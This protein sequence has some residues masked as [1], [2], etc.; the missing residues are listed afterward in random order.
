MP[1]AARLVWLA[2]GIWPATL[3]AEVATAK[4]VAA[5]VSA[6]GSLTQVMFGL[7]CVLAL[8]A[9]CAWLVRKMAPGSLA[10]AGGLKVVGGVL[11]GPKERVVLLEFGD[12]WLLLGVTA[13]Q[14]SLLQ[15]IP[16][17]ED[18]S[19][20]SQSPSLPQFSD[21]MKQFLQKSRQSNHNQG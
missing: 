4:P 15:S 1:I 14:I 2:I 13:G 19:D 3:I 17:P 5:P 10:G 11:V 18:N 12:S 6:A 20:S 8:I 16:R 7:A 21:W 9:A